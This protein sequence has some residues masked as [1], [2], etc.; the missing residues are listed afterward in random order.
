MHKREPSSDSENRENHQI[1]LIK[2]SVNIF[3]ENIVFLRYDYLLYEPTKIWHV[4]WSWGAPAGV[5]W[6]NLIMSV[7]EIIN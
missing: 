1:S 3:I 2:L 6:P 7:I 4:M 5:V